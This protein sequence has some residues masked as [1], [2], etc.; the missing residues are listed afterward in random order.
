MILLWLL[1]AWWHDR[2]PVQERRDFAR[3]WNLCWDGRYAT[4][5]HGTD[6][7]LQDYYDRMHGGL[8]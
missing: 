4:G 2:K 1:F 6:A 8:S 5:P 3:I 7:M